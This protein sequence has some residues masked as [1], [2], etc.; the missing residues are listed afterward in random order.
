M[1][2]GSSTA[3]VLLLMGAGTGCG[4]KGSATDAGAG[5]QA[6]EAGGAGACR[7]NTPPGASV[8]WLEDGVAKC[9]VTVAAQRSTEGANELVQLQGTTL[10]GANVAFAIVAYGTTLE[11]THAC[12]AAG[13][14][15]GGL[16]GTPGTY[17][18][19]FVHTGTKQTCSVTI[20][21]GGT[22]G[23]A[24]ATGAFAATF[25]GAGGALVTGGV[26]DTPV[27]APPTL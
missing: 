27:K 7:A 22:P 18:V 12:S 10:D 17:Y 14:S 2:L 26:F 1:K 3:I 24:N 6:G 9:A 25:T 23:V 11:G 5:G 21:S 8:S 15:D 13:V 16:L 4:S 19:D 20:T